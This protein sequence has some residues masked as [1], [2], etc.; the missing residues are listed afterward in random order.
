MEKVD[1]V[2]EYPEDRLFAKKGL[3]INNFKYQKIFYDNLLSVLKDLGL[4]Y[5]K[6]K[7]TSRKTIKQHEVIPNRIHL[8]YHKYQ[9]IKNVYSIKEAYTLHE[10]YFDKTGYS[11]WAEIANNKK[12]F[13]ES[14]QVDLEEAKIFLESYFEKYH[15]NKLTKYYQSDTEIKISNPYVLVLLQIPNDTVSDLSDILTYDLANIVADVYNDSDFSVVIK[16]HPHD[17]IFNS[18][19]MNNSNFIISNDSLDSLIMKSSAVY[20]V[21]SGAGFEALLYGKPVFTSGHSD[22]H[23]VTTRVKNIAD[24]EKTKGMFYTNDK[25]VKFL[26]F[27]LNKYVINYNDKKAIK[28]KIKEIIN[29]FLN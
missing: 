10:M 3:F 1:F 28:I 16:P 9:N 27:Y 11:G 5:T 29:E 6:I 8:A 4:N 13:E 14:Q 26:Y 22:Y 17:K 15:Y 12:L 25:I 18:S 19:L 23:W 7:R 20:T 2:I 24:I 21:N